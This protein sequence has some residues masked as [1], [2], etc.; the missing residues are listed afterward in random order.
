MRN[1]YDQFNRKITPTENNRQKL[2]KDEESD[3]EGERGEEEQTVKKNESSYAK[4]LMFLF[5][6]VLAH[7]SHV[8]LT[9][10]NLIIARRK[11]PF[12]YIEII[13][14]WNEIFNLLLLHNSF[15]LN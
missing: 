3:R 8:R 9:N 5:S 6:R 7:G 11:E 4:L 12:D 13:D 1:Q 10:S 14:G 2:A 15:E